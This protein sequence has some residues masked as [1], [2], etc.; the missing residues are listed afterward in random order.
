MKDFLTYITNLF[1]IKCEKCKDGIIK[2]DRSE[3]LNITT[4]EVYKCDKCDNELV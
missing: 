2:H 3:L 4:I 1:K